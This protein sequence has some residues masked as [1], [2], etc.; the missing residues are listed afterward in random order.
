MHRKILRLT[1][2]VFVFVCG[3]IVSIIPARCQSVSAQAT[4]DGAGN[5][6]SP[7]LWIPLA[8]TLLIP[9]GFIYWLRQR[10]LQARAED[11]AGVWFSYCRW[12][13]W[14][15]QA[16]WVLWLLLVVE[17]RADRTWSHIFGVQSHMGWALAVLGSAIVPPLLVEILC[18]GL[19]HPVFARIG[20]KE[21]TRA[22]L[23]RQ[24]FWRLVANYLPL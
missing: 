7:A 24:A 23:L 18:T 1:F 3:L 10:A 15:V 16:M 5:S 9:I 14:A 12:S 2:R 13:R 22:D 6:L 8:L 19:A 4:F 11:P 17:L 21:W 20:E